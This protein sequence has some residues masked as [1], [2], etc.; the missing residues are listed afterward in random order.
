M[1]RGHEAKELRRKN[2]EDRQEKRDG[3]HDQQQRALLITERP[4][5]STK[6]LARLMERI[7]K[8]TKHKKAGKK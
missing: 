2:A 3:R 6:E 7:N 8:G 4:G 1:R 5:D